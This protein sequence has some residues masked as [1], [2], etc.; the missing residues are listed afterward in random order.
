MPHDG[1]IENNYIFQQ[2]IQEVRQ[3]NKQICMASIDLANA[4]GSSTHE[5]IITAIEK[6]GAVEDVSNC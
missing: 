2:K 3:K 1:A 6:S 5:A 4:F